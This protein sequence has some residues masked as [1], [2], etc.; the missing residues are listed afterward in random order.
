MRNSTLRRTGRSAA[1]TAAGLSLLGLLTACG[2]DDSAASDPETTAATSA[3]PTPTPTPTDAATATSSSP[4]ADDALITL[5]T[6][7]AGAIVSGSFDVSGTANSPEANV[8]WKLADATG[9]TVKEGYFTAEGW[10]DKLYPYAGTVD[11][12]DV[13]PGEYTFQVRVDDE[14]DGDEAAGST[15]GQVV[16][17]VT[18]K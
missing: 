13:T 9:A 12:S 16:V 4:A 14:A 6:P 1:V 8:P 5:D 10:M 11:V 2:S 3:T 7:T 18:V 17:P 15:G